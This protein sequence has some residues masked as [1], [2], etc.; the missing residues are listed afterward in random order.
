M[1]YKKVGIAI[2]FTWFLVGGTA[3][4]I[5]RDFFLQIIPPSLPLRMPA[6]YISGFFEL[7]GALGLLFAGWRRAAGLGLFILTVLVTPA[8][9]YMWRNPQLFPSISE[10]LL[11]FRLV[12]Q[13]AL[14]ACIWWSTLP[15]RILKS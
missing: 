4:F 2:V 10:D 3:H 9:I 12:L 7:V 13:I 11:A 5:A 1:T 6:V 15:E 14:L 8:N